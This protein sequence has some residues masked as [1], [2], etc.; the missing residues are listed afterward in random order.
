MRANQ[1]N[2]YFQTSTL[3]GLSYGQLKF[4]GMVI[5]TSKDYKDS[6]TVRVALS[7]SNEIPPH[8]DSVI[9]SLALSCALGTKETMLWHATHALVV[10]PFCF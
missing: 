8:A 3:N 1:K 9:A 2:Q 7:E 4:S 5:Y 10:W 6:G